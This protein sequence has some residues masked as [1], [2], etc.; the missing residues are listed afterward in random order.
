MILH[1]YKEYI[2]NTQWYQYPVKMLAHSK[3]SENLCLIDRFIPLGVHQSIMAG[4]HTT[5][6]FYMHVSLSL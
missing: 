3:A 5:H 4:T 6:R 2:P 1:V